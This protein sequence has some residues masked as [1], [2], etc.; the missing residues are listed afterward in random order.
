MNR[1]FAKTSR[2]FAPCAALLVLCSSISWAQ[3]TSERPHFSIRKPDPPAQET[4]TPQPIPLII[5]RDTPIR[6][7]LT[8]RVRI[9]RE[10]VPVSGTVVDTVYAF[11]QAV[12]PAGAVVRG[13]VTRV[14]PVPKPVSYTHLTLPTKRI[15]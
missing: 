3:A 5:S 12:I 13:R 9:A 11:D 1:S 4:P 14:A 10:G 2:R 15:V 7:A 8:R 6:V